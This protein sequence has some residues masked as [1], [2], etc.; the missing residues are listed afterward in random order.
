M[1]TRAI[2]VAALPISKFS[3]ASMDRLL[4]MIEPRKVKL[5]T[6]SRVW[7]PMVI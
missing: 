2:A 7:S 3:S 1:R 6:T 5:S 4:E